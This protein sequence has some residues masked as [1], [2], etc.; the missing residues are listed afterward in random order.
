VLF[1]AA[2]L[3]QSALLDP[4]PKAAKAFVIVLSLVHGWAAYLFFRTGAGPLTRGG[5]W[6]ATWVVLVFLMPILVGFMLPV[7]IYGNDQGGLQAY[8]YSAGPVLLAAFYPQRRPRSITVQ[9][10]LLLALASLVLEPALIIYFV[11]GSWPAG[12]E[13]AVF[14]TALWTSYAYIAG[15]A[16]GALCRLAARKQAEVQDQNYEDFFNFLHSHVKS[17]VAAIK[18]E[19]SHPQAAWEKLSELEQAVSNRRLDL[20]LGRQ[21]PPLAALVSHHIRTFMGSIAFR[22][23]PRIGPMTV[24]RA[25]GL[26]I[27]RALGDLLKNSVMYG[28]T[29]TTVR[30]KPNCDALVLEIADDGP[31]FSDE[32]LQDDATSLCRLRRDIEHLGGEFLKVV[33]GELGGAHMRMVVPLHTAPLTSKG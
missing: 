7:G 20:L 14:S 27:S 1:Q 30:L 33:P 6:L 11:N 32:I 17:G 26:M 21:Q 15:M 4:Y 16:V 5:R 31:D 2:A 19:W 25:A 24:P 8:G 12:H 10:T 28:A 23:T 9:I 3:M 22:E 18:A 29:T 13:R